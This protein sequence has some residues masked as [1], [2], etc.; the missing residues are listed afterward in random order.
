MPEA[1]AS[2]GVEIVFECSFARFV[3]GRSLRVLEEDVRVS[4]RRSLLV[5]HTQKAARVPYLLRLVHD[6][7]F[8]LRNMLCQIGREPR[9]SLKPFPFLLKH[10]LIFL[11]I[12]SKE[13]LVNCSG[14]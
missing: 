12:F 2:V 13:A 7:M 1:H 6:S 4:W 3:G 10:P 14:A 11:R 8:D 9:F 5:S